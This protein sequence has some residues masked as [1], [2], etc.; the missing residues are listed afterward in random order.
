MPNNL[1]RLFSSYQYNDVFYLVIP[2]CGCTFVKNFLWKLDHQGDSH[3][4]PKRV[5]DSDADFARASFFG[6]SRESVRLSNYAFT[7]LRNPVERFLSLYFDK[8]IGDGYRRFVPLRETLVRDFDLDPTASDVTGHRRNCV[9]LIDWISENLKGNT[10]MVRDPHW[11]PLSWRYEIIKEFD[12]KLLLLHNLDRKMELLLQQR[13]PNVA[14]YLKEVERYSSTRQVDRSV[15][16]D[17][18]LNMKISKV[19][20]SD[21]WF[22][23]KTWS[24]W[25]SRKPRRTEDIPRASDVFR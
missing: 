19:Y 12:L 10:T 21:L 1:D 6:H 18:D 20:E 23:H 14:D 13:V 17:S 15:L 2:K 8:V 4:N 9:I 3:P 25:D 7:V 5:H 22:A 24:L 11:T 16:I